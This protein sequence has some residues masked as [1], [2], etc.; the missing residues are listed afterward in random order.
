MT[1]WYEIIET[2]DIDAVRDY[3]ASGADVNAKDSRDKTA[4]DIAR[5]NEYDEIV[6]LL[7]KAVAE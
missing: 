1:T 3:I 7:E 6:A 4:L 2:G 5:E